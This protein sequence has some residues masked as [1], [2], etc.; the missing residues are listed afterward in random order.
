[1]A[2]RNLLFISDYSWILED[3]GCDGLERHAASRLITWGNIAARREN[4]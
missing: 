3:E 2:A 1:M 4:D